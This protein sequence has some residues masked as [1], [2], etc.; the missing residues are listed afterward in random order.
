MPPI[1][2]H[3]HAVDKIATRVEARIAL[4]PKEKLPE[5]EIAG[6]ER[7]LDTPSIFLVVKH[8]GSHEAAT[9]RQPLPVHSLIPSAP[10]SGGDI[11]TPHVDFGRLVVGEKPIRRVGHDHIGREL[12][13]DLMTVATE[14]GDPPIVVI[15]PREISH[16]DT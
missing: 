1:G 13:Q 9:Q 4:I 10:R 6:R 11:A 8:H 3:F 12:R 7:L 5:G 2:R 16:C 15:G 14:N